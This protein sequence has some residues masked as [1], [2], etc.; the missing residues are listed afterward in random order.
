MRWGGQLEF[1]K[2]YEKTKGEKPAALRDRPAL[3]TSNGHY[4][5]AFYELNAGRTHGEL[6]HP[7]PPSEVK[8]YLDLT[9]VWGSERRRWF[10]AVLRSLDA[11]YLTVKLEE[12]AQAEGGEK[13]GVAGRKT[14]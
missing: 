5:E 3:Q 2:D 1:L 7:L 11:T 9:E 4:L 14:G 12:R 13:A 10:Y 6:P 8:A